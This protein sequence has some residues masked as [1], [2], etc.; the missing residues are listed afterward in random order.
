MRFEVIIIIGA[1]VL[2][3]H[4]Y[5]IPRIKWCSSSTISGYTLHFV[6]LIPYFDLDKFWL[7]IKPNSK[8]GFE[9]TRK[10]G[11]ALKKVGSGKLMIKIINEDLKMLVEAYAYHRSQRSILYAI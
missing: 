11:Q 8:E 1:L 9:I 6:T 2:A 5:I 4:V 7:L 3:S 10:Y